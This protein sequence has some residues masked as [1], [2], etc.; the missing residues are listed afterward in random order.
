MADLY[1]Y[2]TGYIDTSYFVYTADAESAQ[3]ATSS[4]SCDA[5]VIAGG[6][7]V[8]GSG[9]L[10]GFATMTVMISHIEGVD[11]FAMSN[12]SLAAEVS[13]I[14]DNNIDVTSAFTQVVSGAKFMY[15]GS[16][17]NAE[18]TITADNLR[19]RFN[20]AASIAA[21]SLAADVE[22]IIGG[23]VLEA[24]AAL[25]ITTSL[26]AQ[27]QRNQFGASSIESSTS[28]ST[29][30]EII[31]GLS[32]ELSITS[33]LTNTGDRIRNVVASLTPRFST[34]SQNV[35]GTD[36][37]I[38]FFFRPDMESYRQIQPGWSV[39]GNPTWIVTAVDHTVDYGQSSVIT[40]TGGVFASGATY[41][42][43]IDDSAKTSLTAYVNEIVNLAADLTATAEVTAV[44]SHIEG[45][46]LT[47]LSNCALFVEAL[48]TR[49]VSVNISMAA[50]LVNNFERTRSVVIQL[51]S[52]FVQ[53]ADVTRLSNYWYIESQASN[54]A[55]TSANGIVVDSQGS[56][57]AVGSDNADNV[58]FLI[59]RTALGVTEWAKE[60]TTGGRIGIDSTDNIYVNGAGSIAAVAKYN[61]LG[62]L[63]WSRR[64]TPSTGTISTQDIAVSDTGD[65]FVIGQTSAGA[66]IIV[67][68]NTSGTLQWQKTINTSTLVGVAVDSTGQP[69]VLSYGTGTNI[70]LIKLSSSTGAV[71]YS[72]QV[73]VGTANNIEPSAITVDSNNNIYISARASFTFPTASRNII[74]KYNSSGTLLWNCAYA[75]A[76]AFQALSTVDNR[77]YAG[78]QSYRLIELE[79]ASGTVIWAKEY[80]YTGDFYI[81]DIVSNS[82]AIYVAGQNYVSVSPQLLKTSMGNWPINGSGVPDL[83]TYID[84]TV[85]VETLSISNTSPTITVSTPSHTNA[86]GT[87]S[88]SDLVLVDDLAVIIASAGVYETATMALSSTSTVVAQGNLQQSASAQLVSASTVVAQPDNNLKSVTANIT[89]NGFVVAA[90]GRIRPELAGLT[91]AFSLSIN[92][93]NLVVGDANLTINTSLTAQA[94]DLDLAEITLTATTALAFEI[95]VVKSAQASITSLAVQTTAPVKTARITKAL[96]ATATLTASALD[97]DFASA[98][99]SSSFALHA[100]ANRWYPRPNGY[101]DASIGYQPQW[102]DWNK[103]RIQDIAIAPSSLTTGFSET[104]VNFGGYLT[105]TRTY[106]VGPTRNYLYINGVEYDISGEIGGG[107]SPTLYDLSVVR[108]AYSTFGSRSFTTPSFDGTTSK[109][110]GGSI[111][112]NAT[113]EWDHSFKVAYSTA[114]PVWKRI[115][116]IGTY[117]LIYRS[118]AGTNFGVTDDVTIMLVTTFNTSLGTYSGVI[119]SNSF[120]NAVI[121]GDIGFGPTFT[122]A[123][124]RGAASTTFTIQSNYLGENSS[125]S[126]PSFMNLAFS[127]ISAGTYYSYDIPNS[128]YLVVKSDASNI[129]FTDSSFSESSIVSQYP[130]I[131]N[132]Q[133]GVLGLYDS[134]GSLDRTGL[135]N[136]AQVALSAVATQTT[137]ARK[138]I[139]MSAT[140]SANFTQSSTVRKIARTSIPL[141]AT[142]SI[143]PTGRR[144]RFSASAFQAQASLT[145]TAKKYNGFVVTSALT[146]TLSAQPYD[147]T[148]AQAALQVQASIEPTALRIKQISAE[149]TAFYVELTAA[150]K[151]A[152]GTILLESTSTLTCAG[153]ITA[154]QPQYM[155]SQ[156]QMTTTGVNTQFGAA[157]IS[158]TSTFNLVPTYLRRNESVMTV[159]ASAVINNSR[160]RNNE[161]TQLGQFFAFPS[162]DN[163]K[164]TGYASTM[165]S[166][167]QLVSNNQILRLAQAN[168]S[169]AFNHEPIYVGVLVRIEAD[170]IVNGFQLTA[171]QVLNIDL[172]YQLKIASETRTLWVEEEYR[173]L[174]INPETRV[175]KIKGNPQL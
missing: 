153:V 49:N 155:F 47:A 91:S 3:T 119:V 20:E 71:T 146:A 111:P 105:I 162:T 150:S 173:L 170:L 60:L 89:A 10:P 77:L 132:D 41:S 121:G 66:R 122:F 165:L 53:N 26:E 166:T 136:Q 134:Y 38:G 40:I 29:V 55:N 126:I 36:D 83:G 87:V 112:A 110:I 117:S 164:I 13:R 125:D 5:T 23:Q 141:Q 103:L 175:N 14:R 133:T 80:D 43:T 30:V 127:S 114:N 39:V 1:Y 37:V 86:A 98:N 157:N 28:Q 50:A 174:S 70:L 58:N 88:V 79:Q 123:M 78:T 107:A 129:L 172:F 54:S 156:T 51:N 101:W 100:T 57:I 113:F 75:S 145:T 33:Q 152:T 56:V 120:S 18:F 68:Y 163:S 8:F 73:G 16:D 93:G 149:F 27:V 4:I 158:S 85:T 130:Y 7:A 42:F 63:Q 64:L 82:T 22:V 45:A 160:T 34:Y 102:N 169:S 131:L 11:L 46:D 168:L 104:L 12:A 15:V 118:V 92:A 19:V 108:G 9:D 31:S 148:K 99:L 76:Y 137:V 17:Q 135:S 74:S 96:T 72:R 6:V 140:L 151:N 81:Y 139:S 2:E 128:G 61:S 62:A 159:T 24:A 147:F 116:T 25:E 142:A 65:S 143:S 97:L 154:D 35:A 106:A 115:C 171:G 161:S 69:Y 67:K 48:V 95:N 84:S 44:I 90:F 167:S 144:V 59:K 94:Q 138:L 52:T 124:D 21:F 32:A 109:S